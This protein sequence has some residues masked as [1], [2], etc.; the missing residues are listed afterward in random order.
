MGE[1]INPF[2]VRGTLPQGS[3]INTIN[4]AGIY[5]LNGSYINTPFSGGSWGNFIILPG[6][7]NSQIITELTNYV[8]NIYVRANKTESWEKLQYAS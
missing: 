1:L 7:N 2:K 8:Y 3:D 5:A 4:D 6:T